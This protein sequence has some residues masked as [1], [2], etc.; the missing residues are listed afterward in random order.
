MAWAMHVPL[1][2]NLRGLHS[3]II[4]NFNN[5]RSRDKVI[6]TL[7]L[8]RQLIVPS[9]NSAFLSRAALGD[10]LETHLSTRSAG[11]DVVP[12]AKRATLQMYTTRATSSVA[13][14]G[15]VSGL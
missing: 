5:P 1:S 9:C 2:A 14:L 3:D 12:E 6:L 10:V 7:K 8:P 13:E 4:L 15:E 11:L